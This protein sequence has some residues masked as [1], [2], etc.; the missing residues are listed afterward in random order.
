MIKYENLIRELCKDIKYIIDTEYHLFPINKYKYAISKENKRTISQSMFS[1]DTGNLNP[2][3]I[4]SL[5]KYIKLPKIN[6][7]DIKDLI[8][9]ICKIGSILKNKYNYN[10]MISYL[11]LKDILE[12]EKIDINKEMMVSMLK[13]F[14]IENPNCF[15]IKGQ[16]R[17]ILW[18]VLEQ[19]KIK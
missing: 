17:I 4:S 12:K 10:R 2:N 13:Y 14:D 16:Q 7:S 1:R 5:R 15:Q 9:K 8:E 18:I 19:Q 3:A 6:E 11:E